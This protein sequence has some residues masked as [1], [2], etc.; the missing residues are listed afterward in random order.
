MTLGEVVFACSW[1]LIAVVLDLAGILHRGA[2]FRVQAAG[3]LVMN[4]AEVVNLFAH[5]HSGGVFPALF[6]G[7]ALFIGGAILSAREQGTARR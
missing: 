2:G 5:L 6:A 1:L 4:T 7:F 3:L